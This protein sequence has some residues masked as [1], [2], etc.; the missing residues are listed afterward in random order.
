MNPKKILIFSTSYYPFVAGAEVAIKEIT[1]RISDIEFHLITAK[2]DARLAFKEKIG[3]VIVYRL[4]VGIP[5]FDKLILPFE[6]ALFTRHLQKKNNYDAFWCMMATFASGAAYIKN[7]FSLNKVPI[8]LTLQEGDSETHIKYRWFG[9]LNL[10]WRLAIK[11]AA[12]I[13]VLSSYLAQRA[14]QF[15]YKRE[16]KIVPNGVDIKRFDQDVN[17][18]ERN[19]MRKSLGLNENDIAVVTTSRLVVKNGVGDVI[20]AIHKLPSNFK[21]IVFGEGYLEEN[22]KLK[23]KNLKLE[24]RVIMKGFIDHKDMPKYLKACDIFTRPSLSEGF[25]NSF[26]EAMAAKI[27]V[28]ATRVG[29]IVDFLEDGVTGYVCEPQN[30]ESIANALQ[31][32]ASDPSKNTI[33]QNAYKMVTEK[34]NWNLI[35][36]KMKEVFESI[37]DKK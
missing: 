36:S 26:I 6:G 29:G 8:I 3:N 9:L 15:G 31:R 14:K 4:G 7:I 23:I 1:D 2:M 37:S 33:I 24:D 5:I 13:T 27:P 28:V 18:E 16:V 35:S 10:S 12:E 17:N 32:V 30:S 11:F 22:L 21:F 20:E 34:Y 19:G 25:G